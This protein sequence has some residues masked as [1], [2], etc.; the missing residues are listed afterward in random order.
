VVMFFSISVLAFENGERY[1]ILL[2]DGMPEFYPTLY[3]TKEVRKVGHT[4]ETIKNVLQDIKQMLMWEQDHGISI[5]ERFR[6]GGGLNVDEMQSLVDFLGYTSE[7]AERLRS[8]VKLLQNAYE[9]VGRCSAQP[10]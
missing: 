7:T 9:Y 1:P 2:R 10:N 6:E 5:E 8:G 3:V 4:K